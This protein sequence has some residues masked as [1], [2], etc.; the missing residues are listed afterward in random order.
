MNPIRAPL[1]GIAPP[2]PAD[3]VVVYSVLADTQ[4]IEQRALDL[5]VEQTVE[6]TAALWRAPEVRGRTVGRVERIE[7][8]AD[9]RYEVEIR[10]PAATVGCE[11]PQFFSVLFG[12]ASLM[13]GVRVERI[14]PGPALASAL[15]GP[16]FGIRGVRERVRVFDRPLVGSALKPLGRSVAELA[17]YAYRLA[18]G[19]M[20]LLKDDHGLTNQACCAF[21]AR[22]E[23]CADAVRRANRETGRKTLYFASITG[24]LDEVLS[25]ALFAKAA[26]ADGVLVSPLVVGLD[27]LRLLAQEAQVLVMAHPALA[28]AF[29]ASPDHGIAHSALLGTAMRLCGADLVIFPSWGG[30]FPFTREVC[31]GIARSLTQEVHGLRASW[32]VPA[33][34]LTLDR[35]QDLLS[36]HGMDTVFLVGS[37]LYEHSPDLT[38]N[39]R[40]FRSL[41]ESA[42]GIGP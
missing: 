40:Y 30:R 5:A 15:G 19:G 37:A 14:M 39:A 42:R 3:L 22:V 26:G 28:G 6:V 18:L 20:D 34:G 16:R 25:R 41:V 12:N 23:A 38:E 9:G 32:P 36:V 1:G 13:H 17:G 21:Q 2:D 27:A 11:V 10:F 29:F 8:I 31:A 35:V 4:S 24:P 7:P 33:G